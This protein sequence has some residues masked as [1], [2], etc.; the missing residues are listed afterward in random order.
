MAPYTAV[1]KGMELKH[2]SIASGSLLNHK[3]AVI[4]TKFVLSGSFNWATKASKKN[5]EN[6]MVT[7]S[8]TFV[9]K[10]NDLFNSLWRELPHELTKEE[11]QDFIKTEERFQRDHNGGI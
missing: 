6:I 9:R 4:D 3:F 8:K 10:F 5:H 1:R 2:T 11:S 7:S